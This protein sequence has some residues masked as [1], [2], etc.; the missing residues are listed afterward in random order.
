MYTRWISRIQLKPGTFSQSFIL[1]KICFYT[2]IKEL[3][4]ICDTIF[5]VDANVVWITTFSE[6]TCKR[7]PLSVALSRFIPSNLANLERRCKK[8]KTPNNS[9]HYII[10]SLCITRPVC[11]SYLPKGCTVF[12]LPMLNCLITI[13]VLFFLSQ[14]V[15]PFL[16]E[17]K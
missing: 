10:S 13:Y 7:T 6:A 12:G 17:V 11:T 1:I 9:K 3:C 4:H 8:V 5:T 2:W 16:K 14:F 15:F